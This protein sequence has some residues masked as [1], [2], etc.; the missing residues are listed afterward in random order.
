[1]PAAGG[2]TVTVNGTGL[3]GLVPITVTVGGIAATGVKITTFSHVLTFVAPP[4]K[5][6]PADVVITGQIGSVRV[7]NALTYQ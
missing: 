3:A 4:H 5:A 2:T 7:P 6:G 1:V